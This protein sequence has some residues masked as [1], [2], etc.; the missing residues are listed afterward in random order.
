M[1][2]SNF[3][4]GW[5]V[6]RINIF[7]FWILLHIC[8]IWGWQ[9]VIERWQERDLY[10]LLSRKSLSL[11]SKK[12][13]N[14]H[15]LSVP[16]D[17]LWNKVLHLLWNLYRFYG[18]LTDSF[19]V[20]SF[21]SVF[22]RFLLDNNIRNLNKSYKGKKGSILRQVRQPCLME[23]ALEHQVIAAPRHIICGPFPRQREVERSCNLIV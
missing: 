5:R 20:S 8:W 16:Y 6:L 23:Q 9:R 14:R 15:I 11:L 18:I 22:G 10:A 1:V 19:G 3:Q 21:I 17:H 12:K 2:F 13:R 4:K 7:F